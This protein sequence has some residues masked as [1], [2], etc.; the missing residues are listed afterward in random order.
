MVKQFALIA[1]VAAAALAAADAQSQAATRVRGTIVAFDAATMTIRARDGRELSL[2]LA[3]DLGVTVTKAARF[4]DLKAGDYVGSATTRAANGDDVA[5][6]VH[7]LAPSVAPGQGPWDLAPGTTMTNANV[8][9][10]VVAA[11]GRELTL[12]S[13][14]GRHRIVV[15]DGAPIL[16]S[17]PGTRADLVPGEWVFVAARSGADGGVTAL[18]IQV[19]KDGVAPAH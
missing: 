14:Q 19:G 9:S 1:C 8:V 5:I 11:S 7:Y 16:G 4:D 3:D 17:V 2:K 13:P 18:R 10:T 6:E 15:P 12:Q